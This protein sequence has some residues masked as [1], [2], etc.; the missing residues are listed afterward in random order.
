MLRSI[1]SIGSSWIPVTSSIGIYGEY[2][3]TVGLILRHQKKSYVFIL[4]CFLTTI[5][6][7]LR[8][9]RVSK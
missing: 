3:F 2:T 5:S 4:V 7:K 9:Y 1:Q 8:A 6:L